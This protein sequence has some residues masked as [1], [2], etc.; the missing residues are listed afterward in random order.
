MLKLQ[1][2]QEHQ[3]KQV[4]GCRG[5][6][7]SYETKRFF[8]AIHRCAWTVRLK[9]EEG[10]RCKILWYVLNGSFWFFFLQ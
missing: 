8:F 5:E 7:S 4:A 3:N 1:Q 6:R 2:H 9:L 10:A